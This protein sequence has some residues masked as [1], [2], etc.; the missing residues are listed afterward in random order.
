MEE[1]FSLEIF[2]TVVILIILAIGVFFTFFPIV[3]LTATKKK[4]P[5]DN[6]TGFDFAFR[7]LFG[8]VSTI[9]GIWVLM[10]GTI[11]ALHF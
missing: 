9:F 2:R 1:L 10:F 7:F 4:D 6:W 8:F 5:Q 11:L 3:F